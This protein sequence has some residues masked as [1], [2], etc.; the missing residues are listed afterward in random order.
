MASETIYRDIVAR[1]EPFIGT[2]NILVLHGARQVGKTHILYL[3]I[4]HLKQRGETTV[5]IDL[6]DSRKAEILD[7]GVE[8]FLAYLNGAGFAAGAFGNGKK[9]FV[10]IDE[11]QYLENPSSFLKLIADHHKYMQLIVSGSSS[12]AIKS[13]FTDSLAGRTVDFEIY[14]LSF[15]EFLRFKG[16]KYGLRGATGAYHLANLVKLYEEYVLYGGYPKIVLENS[17]EKKETYLQQIIDTYVRKD[18][19]DLAGIRDVRKF[20]SLVKLLASQSG[21]LLNA[22]AAAKTCALAVQTVRNYLFILENTYVIKLV[23]P[24]SSSAKVEVVK[25]PKIFFLDTGLARMLRFKRLSAELPGDAFETSVFSELVKKYGS[26]DI[27]YWRNRN[28]NEIDFILNLRGKLVPCE[29]KE[30][31][32]NFRRGAMSSFC[33]KYKVEDYKVAGIRGEKKDGHCVYPWEL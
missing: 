5:F 8:A 23:A 33:D 12:F 28:Q 21:Q 1:I 30:S 9:L 25:A 32:A 15:E 3:L 7:S 18:I 14:N 20:N 4:D 29:V 11:I 10:F 2:D 31:F 27:N 19:G 16:E 13:K 6:E 26:R 22:A 24:F 17:V